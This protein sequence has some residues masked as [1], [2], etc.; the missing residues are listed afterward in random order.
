MVACLAMLQGMPPTS[1]LIQDNHL[2][3]YV[4]SNQK[5]I[6]IVPISQQPSFPKVHVYLALSKKVCSPPVIRGGHVS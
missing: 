6:D 3:Q 2:N 4:K 1:L 5:H